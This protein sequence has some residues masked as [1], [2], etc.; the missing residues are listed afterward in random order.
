MSRGKYVHVYTQVRMRMHAYGGTLLNGGLTA[1]GSLWWHNSDR[2]NTLG[3]VLVS[4]AL[5]LKAGGF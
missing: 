5:L 4:Q 3:E 1:K 2:G